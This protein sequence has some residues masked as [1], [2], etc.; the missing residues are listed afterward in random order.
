MKTKINSSR[1]I[2]I[3]GPS[4]SGKTTLVESILYACNQIHQRGQIKDNNTVSD[5]LP[6]EQ[7]L[8]MSIS[9]GI[10]DAQY[11][12]EEYTFPELAEFV[13]DLVEAGGVSGVGSHGQLQGLG[14]HWEVWSMAAG[15]ISNH[16]MLKVATIIGAYAIG[17]DK[18]IGS[19]EKG[20]LADFIVI[21]KDYLL[22]RKARLPR[23]L[24]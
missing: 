22:S 21:D 23:S 6:E 18:E 10:S 17:L 4:Q 9:A 20:K 2:T 13:K 14:Y 24:I 16:D 3:I 12:D 7:E 5:F 15:G 1:C 11:M 8:K 19:I